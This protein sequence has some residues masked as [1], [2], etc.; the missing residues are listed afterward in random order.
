MRR[1]GMLEIVMWW[2]TGMLLSQNMLR[3]DMTRHVHVM[4][5]HA[6][7]HTILEFADDTPPDLAR[8]EAALL[9]SAKQHTHVAVVHS[10]TTRCVG[11]QHGMDV[12]WRA[13]CDVRGGLRQEAMMCVIVCYLMRV[14][15]LMCHVSSYVMCHLHSGIINDVERIGQLVHRYN[16]SF[17][18]EPCHHSVLYRSILPI[19]LSGMMHRSMCTCPA[20]A[21]AEHG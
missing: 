15:Y 5:A 6:I 11:C 21:R 17:I 2:D 14:F 3:R 20:C 16:K 9:S 7:P 10:E 19:M 13:V 1:D 12:K 8:I 4:Q 18:V